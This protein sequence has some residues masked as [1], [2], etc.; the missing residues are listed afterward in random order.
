VRTSIERRTLIRAGAGV[1]VIATGAIAG[2]LA[3]ARRAEFMATKAATGLASELAATVARLDTLLAQAPAAFAFFDDDGTLTRVNEAFAALFGFSP[4]QLRGRRIANALPNI[5]ARAQPYI[6]HVRNTGAPVVDLEVTGRTSAEPNY[7]HHWLVTIFPVQHQPASVAAPALPTTTASGLGALVVDITERKRAEQQIALLA[8]ASGLY[9]LELGSDD[10]MERVARLAVPTFADACIVHLPAVHPDDRRGMIAHRDARTEARLRE[11][12]TRLPGRRHD[13]PASR[14]MRE[15]EVDFVACIT[16]DARRERALD[17]TH[18]EYFGLLAGRSA[19]TVPLALGERTLGAITFLYTDASNREYRA[20]D[21]NVAAE[22][23]RRCAQVLEN[24]RLAA[25]ADRATARLRILARVGELLAVELDSERRLRRVAQVML[26]EFADGCGVYLLEEGRLR[27]VAAGH[28]DPEIQGAL[29]RAVLPT[30]ALSDNLPPCEAIRTGRAVLVSDLEPAVADELVA[31]LQTRPGARQPLQSFLAVP[32][33]GESGPIGA[34]G[35]GFTTSGRHYDQTDIP[36]AIELARRVAP[37]VEN[38]RRYEGN[39]EVIEV[40]QRT[41]LPAELPEVPGI[42][43]AGRYRPGVTGLRIGGDW[44]DATV[45]ADGRLFLA[46]GD[47][48]GHGVRAASSMGRLRNALQIYGVEHESPGEMLT[49]L[50]RHFSSFPDADIA[51]IG[52]VVHDPAR[53]VAHIASAG[54]LPP[55]LR[56][57]DGTVR[58]LEP[59]RGMPICATQHAKYE[60]CEVPISPGAVLVLYTDGLVERRQ[61]ALDTGLERLAGAVANST[62]DVEQLADEIIDALVPPSAPATDDVALLVVQ[63]EADRSSFRMRVAARPR[64]LARLRRSIGDWATTLGAGPTER[65]DVVLAVNE[66]AA[67]AVEHA[68]G[69]DGAKMEVTGA[70]NGAGML[71]VRVR[72]FGRWRPGRTWSDGGRGLALIRGLMDEVAVDTTENGTTVLMRHRLGAD[73]SSA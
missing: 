60:D 29:E 15:H 11:L 30:H 8:A 24:V 23:G 14:V 6:E 50:N 51:T 64:E 34:L 13:D 62:E 69:P 53:G 46:I 66:A 12:F 37:A 63:F 19:I 21:V 1:G 54:H 42:S 27:L 55:L 18:F 3:R 71:E 40:L 38:A 31:N 35:L 67:N 9:A 20:D 73:R 65:D 17:E 33:L 61:E 70:T 7:E 39:R 41:L 47:V 44:Y 52:I 58:F 48:V 59:P 26:P 32:L 68:Y 16:D 28:P 25:V 4:K 36:V 2:W 56:E 49:A 57:L 43:I 22:L 45:L 10:A 72:D 5:W